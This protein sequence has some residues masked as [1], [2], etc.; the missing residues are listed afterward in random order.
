MPSFDAIAGLLLG[1]ALAGYLAA[2]V[3]LRI[4][5]SRAG[6]WAFGLGWG[7]N[8]LTVLFNWLVCG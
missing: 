8:V 5:K 2:G 3:L 7:A 6:H 1:T 4:G